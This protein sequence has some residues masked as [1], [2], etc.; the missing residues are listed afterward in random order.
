MILLVSIFFQIQNSFTNINALL[1]DNAK[2]LASQIKLNDCNNTERLKETLRI[3][4]SVSSSDLIALEVIWQPEGQG[5]V[6]S[7][8]ELVTSYPNLKHL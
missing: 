3:L 5:D 7:A 8:E 6:L 4:G 1:V 2:V